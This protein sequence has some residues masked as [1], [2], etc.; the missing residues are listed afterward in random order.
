MP[1]GKYIIA[2]SLQVKIDKGNEVELCKLVYRFVKMNLRL[3]KN[4]YTPLHMA[5]DEST[6][7]DD[8]HVNDVVSFP[9]AILAKLLIK[10]G[11]AVNVVDS[12]NNSP[13]HI[14]VRYAKPISD[15]LTLHNIIMILLN[16]GAHIDMCN[17]EGKTPTETSTTGVAE[18]I[19]RTQN[20]ISLKCICARAVK[21]HKVVYKEQLPML[22]EEFV[23]IH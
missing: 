1:F 7:V 19:L 10:C 14:I 2:Y 11:A 18:I 15:F 6:L 13:L 17:K 21:K 8:F 20:R 5:C 16:A 3:R 12:E 9:N 22:L 23:D 4:N